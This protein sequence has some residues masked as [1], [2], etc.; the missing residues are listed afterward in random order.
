MENKEIKQ[1][2]T[3]YKL[4]DKRS[5]KAMEAY[6]GGHFR[7]HTMNSWNGSTSY[8]CNMKLYRL[9]LDQETMDTLYDMIQVPEFYDDLSMLIQD[10]NTAHN[11]Q[12]QAGWNG[13]SGGYLV[14]YQGKK[15]PSKHRSF[16]TKCGQKNFKSV[17]ETG[18]RCG[19]CG[20]ETRVD[21]ITPPMEIVVFPGRGT[22]QGED[23]GEWSMEELRQRTVLVQEF[24]QLADA[25][26]SMAVH[27]AQS[28]KVVEETDY[29]PVSR[30]RL[31]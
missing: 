20:R 21:F 12:W 27:L 25:I 1:A 13:R 7:Y 23:F 28:C 19:V 31:A 8:A 30:L 6:L 18:T 14:L 3:F 17:A 5:R 10:F 2:H 16:C 26:T 15:T 9:D 22:D 4:V 11:Y 24:D 29:V